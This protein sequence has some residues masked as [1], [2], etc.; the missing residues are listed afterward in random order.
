[1]N[2]LILHGYSDSNKGDLAIVVGM[3]KG[4]RSIEPGAH[5][6][7]QSVYSEDDPDFLFHHRFVKQ[8]GLIVEQMAIPSPYIDTASHSKL[9]NFSALIN[10]IQSSLGEFLVR[11]VPITGRIF[12]RQSKAVNSIKRADVVL[13]KGGQY[14]YN[15]QGGIRA[16]LYLWRILHPI[17]IAHYY[18]R[19]VVMLGQSVG[20]LIDERGRTM[21]KRALA[22]CARLIVREQK[23]EVLLNGLGLQALVRVAPDFAFLIEPRRPEAAVDVLKTLDNGEWLGITVVNWSYPG[24]SNPLEK[25]AAYLEAVFEVACRVWRDAGLRVALFPQVTVQHHGESDLDL[26]NKLAEKFEDAAIPFLLVEKDLSPDELSFLYGRCK[27]LLGTR[28]HSCILAAC[29]FTPVVAIR[30]QGFKTEGVMAELGLE[31]RV[32]DIS[33]VQPTPITAAI[34]ESILQHDKIS[35][36]IRR[37]VE[38]FRTSLLNHLK[39]VLI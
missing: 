10:L 15:D 19:P 17:F 8:L 14:I 27:V 31:H 13:L 1:L 32:F 26:L 5:I 34:M 22:L 2:I 16:A 3:V 29:A 12:K 20:P 37:R 39:E 4:I 9:R 21:T 33:D 7:L 6:T 36:E 25:S 24:A 30:Y 28:L 23:S 11:Y 35:D 18:R 38:G